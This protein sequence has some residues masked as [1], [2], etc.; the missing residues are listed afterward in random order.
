MKKLFSL[1]LAIMLSSFLAGSAIAANFEVA[2]NLILD[3]PLLEDSYLAGGNVVIDSDI[4]GDLYVAGG[5]VKING[6]ITEDLVV[7]GGRVTVL[8]NIGDDLRIIGGD[9]TI[10][11]NVGD[12]L[13]MIGGVA[14]VSKKSTIGGS[15]NVG[16]G[17]LTLEGEVKKD[18]YG[19]VGMLVL[20]GI[21]GGDVIVTVEEKLDLSEHAYIGG[22]LKYSGLIE[23]DI[24]EGVVV[25]EVTFNQFDTEEELEKVTSAYFIYRVISYLSLLL[26]LFVFVML[27]PRAL[28]KAGNTTKENVLKTLGMGVLTAIVGFVGSILLMV[29]VIGIPLG[30]IIFAFLFVALY[31]SRIFVAAW[32]ASYVVNYAKKKKYLK[33]HL[34]FGMAVALLVYYLIAMIPYIGW[35]ISLI[36]FLIGLG[37]LVMMKKE[38]YMFLKGKKMV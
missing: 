14:D 24:P 12:D 36:L 38:Y 10:Y 27:A 4:S 22:D 30:L 6:N 35:F 5:E 7:I 9:V 25:G 8:G 28:I 19:G 26:L 32:L 15:I 31:I 3:A 1:F 33:L 17:Y 18:L 11:G 37:S 2:E 34:F 20:G 16:A 13:I 29:T 21:V 23:M